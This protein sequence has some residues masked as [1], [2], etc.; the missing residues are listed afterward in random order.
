M[1]YRRLLAAGKSLQK[2]VTAVARELLGFIWAVGVEAERAA[3][4]ADLPQAA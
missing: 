1:R 3:H 4:A 2:V